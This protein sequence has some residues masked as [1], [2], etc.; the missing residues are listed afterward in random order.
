MAEE[1]YLGPSPIRFDDPAYQLCYDCWLQLKQD[2][3][4]PAWREWRWSDIPAEL[5]P[6]FIVVDVSHD[7]VDF[8]YRFWGTA[9]THMHGVDLTHKSIK[10]I[11]SPVT[12]K[13]TADQYTQVAEAKVAIGSLHQMQ[14]SEY[15]IPHSQLALR[16]PMSNDGTRVDQIVSFIDWRNNREQIKIEHIKV[17]G[18]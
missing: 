17:Y 3:W 13:S 16:M 6:Y 18:H 4:A 9:N 12:A 2:R 14:T 1:D 11:R 7:P 15:L 8:H 10:D 5:I